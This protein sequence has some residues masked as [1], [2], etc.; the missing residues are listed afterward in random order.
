MSKCHIPAAVGETVEFHAAV[1]SARAGRPDGGNRARRDFAGL[2]ACAFPSRVG[3]TLPAFALSLAMLATS[4]CQ[5]FE[6]READ[7][8]PSSEPRPAPS[9]PMPEAVPEANLSTA[10]KYLETGRGDAARA[11]LAELAKEAPNSGVLTSLLRQIDEPAAQLLPGPYRE[12]VV[13]AGESLSLIAARELGDPLMFYALARLNEIEVPAQV[14]AGAVLKI[15]ATAERVG[16]GERAPDVVVEPASEITIPEIESVADYLARSGQKDQARAMLIGK[17]GESEAVGAE[18]TRE[19]LARLTLEHAGEMRGEGELARAMEVIEESLGV[20][21]PSPQRT[22][23]AQAREE[24]RADVLREEALRLRDRGELAA[25]YRAAQ[26]AESL[27]PATD[28]AAILVDELRAELVE[29]LHNEA[30]VA[31]RDRNVDH[32]IR[33]WQSLLEVVPDFEPA[34]VY[35]ARARLLRERLDEP[36]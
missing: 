2:D 7:P 27:V 11:L 26:D 34:R 18:S 23:L 29:S 22:A 14:P 1:R 13:G 20:M 19:L 4:G 28:G 30:L 25:A 3:R 16:S 6:K 24:L 32:A 5:L 10:M 17:L 15:P 12:V 36:R 8:P 31:W 35:L 21:S 9:E 33:T